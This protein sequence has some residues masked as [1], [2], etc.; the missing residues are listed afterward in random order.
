MVM[1]AKKVRKKRSLKTY[2]IIRILIMHRRIGACQVSDIP[3]VHTWRDLWT[4]L[5]DDNVSLLTTPHHLQIAIRIKIQFRLNTM[6]KPMFSLPSVEVSSSIDS[7]V[8]LL[9]SLW[10]FLCGTI[11]G[12]LDAFIVAFEFVSTSDEYNLESSFVICC[13]R[14]IP[15]VACV[16]IRNLK[17]ECQ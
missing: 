2:P 15:L 17:I 7:S 8:S 16:C 1:C 4:V 12:L 14:L 10:N 6:E 9:P 5:R 11:V 3:M 13:H